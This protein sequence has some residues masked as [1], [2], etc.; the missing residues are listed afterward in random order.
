M[1]PRHDGRGALLQATVRPGYEQGRRRATAARGPT[2]DRRELRPAS[3]RP[4]F[5]GPYVFKHQLAWRELVRW[6]RQ[7]ADGRFHLG[8]EIAV[9]GIRSDP[10]GVAPDARRGSGFG[11]EEHFIYARPLRCPRGSRAG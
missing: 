6:I 9:S 11:G 3:A 10:A 4:D 2:V 1:V 8:A 7:S 5:S